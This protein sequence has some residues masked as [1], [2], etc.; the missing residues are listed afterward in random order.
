VASDQSSKEALATDFYVSLLGTARPRDFDLSLHAVGLQPVDLAGLEARFTMEEIWDAVRAMP[1]NRSPG[2]DGFSWEFY[3]SC[4][5]VI[6]EDVFAALHAIWIG[7]DQGFDSLNDALI[8]LLPKKDGAIDLA[9][10]RPISLVH[11]F[12]RLL[13]KVLARRLAP[14]MSELVADNQTAFIR[15]RC[16]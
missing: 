15:G 8:T 11:S 1:G 13:T 7:R 16:I 14:R 2:P 3:R 6:K 12:A 5:P 10:F 4:W 9:D